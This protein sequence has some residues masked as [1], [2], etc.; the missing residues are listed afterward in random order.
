MHRRSF[1]AGVSAL[2]ASISGCLGTGDVSDTGD[3]YELTV[4]IEHPR[5]V[6]VA[7]GP[8]SLSSDSSGGN[9]QLDE[10]M[11]RIGTIPDEIAE[12]VHTAI[13]D[14]YRGDTVPDGLEEYVRDTR[15]VI[16]DDVYRVELYEPDYDVVPVDI[17]VETTDTGFDKVK[18]AAD[19]ENALFESELLNLAEYTFETLTGR[20]WNEYRPEDAAAFKL[21]MTNVS[22]ETIEVFGG[23]PAP[24]GVLHAETADMEDYERR[25]VWSETY[26]G[27]EHVSVDAYGLGVDALQTVTEMRADETVTETYRVA[28]PPGEYRVEE[29]VDV[30]RSDDED[31]MYPYTLVIEVSETEA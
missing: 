24:F 15:Y 19:E 8:S 9:K 16:G 5:Y 14:E 20:V 7:W 13:D 10:D 1:L 27:N 3:T 4:D 12:V 2:A 23:A 6:V 11:R 28:F 17:A 31:K 25:L 26:V 22:D 29:T 21:S 30:S 18:A